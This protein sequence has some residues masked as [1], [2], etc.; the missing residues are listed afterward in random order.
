MCLKDRWA[1]YQFDCAVVYF[2]TVIENK[3]QEQINV[4]GESSPKWVA[5]YELSQ[6][7]TD[8]FVIGDGAGDG[9]ALP[10]HADGLIFDEVS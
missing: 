4:G 3:S 8:G 6:L 7:L 5:K 2:G 9:D 1:S 10:M